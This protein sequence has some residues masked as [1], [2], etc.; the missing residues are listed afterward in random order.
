MEPTYF[1]KNFDIFGKD[2]NDNQLI[3][4]NGVDLDI[5]KASS[6]SCDGG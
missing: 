1:L 4:S 6:F 5:F 3:L 2:E